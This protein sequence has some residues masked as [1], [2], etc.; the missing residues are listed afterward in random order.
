MD[1]LVKLVQQDKEIKFIYLNMWTTNEV[2][3]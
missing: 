2:G 1:E 3:L